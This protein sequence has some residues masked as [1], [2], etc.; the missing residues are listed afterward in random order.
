MTDT[1]DR[2]IAASTI[3]A[4]AA[5]QDNA[6]KG[7]NDAVLAVQGVG[8]NTTRTHGFICAV[9]NSAVKEAEAERA[10]GGGRTAGVCTELAQKLRSAADK[11]E[12]TDV[13]EKEK[14][15]DQMPP[16]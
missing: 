16:R 12:A 3:R 9:T 15:D 2:S 5:G 14:L 6:A 13:A 8:D 4:L 10:T 1:E 7:I 11:Y